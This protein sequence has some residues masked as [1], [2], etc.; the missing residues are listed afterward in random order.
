MKSEFWKAIDEEEKREREQE[1][2]KWRFKLE[3]FKDLN[4]QSGWLLFLEDIDEWLEN[5]NLHIEEIGFS[6]EP[7]MWK[8]GFN[9]GIRSA[10]MRVK[11]H[12]KRTLEEEEHGET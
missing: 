1:E 10:L 9:Q 6:E 2:E 4:N 5:L 3:T 7:S 12:V 8:M 11:S